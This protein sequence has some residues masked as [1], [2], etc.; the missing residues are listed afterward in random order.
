MKSLPEMTVMSAAPGGV[1]TSILTITFLWTM[2][3]SAMDSKPL[4]SKILSAEGEGG[5]H[6]GYAQKGLS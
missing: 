2:A 6:H 1:M 5:E 3:L 4:T